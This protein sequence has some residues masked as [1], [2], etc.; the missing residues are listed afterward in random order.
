MF[1]FGSS[2]SLAWFARGALYYNEI[3]YGMFKF[4]RDGNVDTSI[5]IRYTPPLEQLLWKSRKQ[6]VQ[7][8]LIL[9]HARVINL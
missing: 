5:L 9:F 7:N 1:T 8:Q 3:I 4:I 6:R 2:V